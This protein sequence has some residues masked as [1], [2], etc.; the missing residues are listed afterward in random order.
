MIR[1]NVPLRGFS[2]CSFLIVIAY[3][4]EITVSVPCRGLSFCS[5]SQMKINDN[6]EVW[7]F[8]PCRGLSFCSVYHSRIATAP[9]GFRPLSGSF[10]LF[11]VVIRTNEFIIKG[12]RPLSG[13][14]FLFYRGKALRLYRISFRPLSG[15]FFLF[16]NGKI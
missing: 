4:F 3:T 1:Y 15:S 12:F 2:F 13:S 8:V 6:L 7:V 11:E 14:F 9:E 5:E 10:F 16:K